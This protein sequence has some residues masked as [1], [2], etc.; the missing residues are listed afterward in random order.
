MTWKLHELKFVLLLGKDVWA[1]T[2]RE[3]YTEMVLAVPNLTFDDH[4]KMVS[5]AIVK[6]DHV[7]PLKT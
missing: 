6:Y 7:T 1:N 3:K 2:I 4:V 5:G